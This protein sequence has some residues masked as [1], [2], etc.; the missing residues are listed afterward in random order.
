MSDI[1]LGKL[2]F[3]DVDVENSITKI[4]SQLNKAEQAALKA[5]I[6]QKEAQDKVLQTTVETTKKQND[7]LANALAEAQKKVDEVQKQAVE[8]VKKTES[9]TTA[10]FSGM[11]K[12]IKGFLSTVGTLTGLGTITAI[13]AGM[14]REV[15]K[16]VDKFSRTKEGSKQLENINL[17]W[18]R[19]KA[20]AADFLQ[21]A[22][23]K[24][25][26]I[27]DKALP[28]IERG[29]RKVT[30]FIAGTAA[31]TKGVVNN[32]VSAVKIGLNN[33]EILALKP[34]GVFSA[35]KIAALEE[36]NKKLRESYV[37]I[38]AAAKK[39]YDDQ[40]ASADKASASAKYV[41]E[42]TQEQKKALD[43]YRKAIEDFN[44][45]TEKAQLQIL[46]IE[47]P[48]KKLEKEKELALKAIDDLDKE[49]R[50]AAKKAGKPLPL[51]YETEIKI[52]KDA[53]QLQ[54]KKD[55]Q[56]LIKE[57]T[58][59]VLDGR[60]VFATNLRTVSGDDLNKAIEE[61]FGIAFDIP[62]NVLDD[63]KKAGVKLSNI[64]GYIFTNEEG[65]KKIDEGLNKNERDF[66]KKLTAHVNRTVEITNDLIK[67]RDEASDKQAGKQKNPFARLLGVTD[68]D[69]KE[70]SNTA[71]QIAGNISSIFTT[72]LDNQIQQ[73]D[74]FIQSIRQRISEVENAVN[75][76]SELQARGSANNLATKKKELEELRAQELAKTKENEE[77]NRKRARAQLAADALQQAS[78]LITAG[79][80]IF[81][82]EGI[83]KGAAGIITGILAVSAM[84]AFMAKLRAQAR[85]QSQEL[86][87]YRGGSM[88]K[89][90]GFVNK[91]GRTDK[92]GGKGHKI[93]NSNLVVG[94]KEFISKEEV[95]V[96]HEKFLYD[97]NTGM[98]DGVDLGKIVRIGMVHNVINKEEKKGAAKKEAAV[99][100]EKILYDLNVG[101]F[102]KLDLSQ[103]VR[104]G[105][106][107]RAMENARNEGGLDVLPERIQSFKVDYMV[108]E[109]HRAKAESKYITKKQMQKML[110]KH[111]R[112]LRAHSDEKP[113]YIPITKETTGYLLKSKKVNEK[114]ELE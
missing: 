79:T 99:K 57:L 24:I 17:Q 100:R 14:G 63:A 87:A 80:G 109:K 104:I 19:M 5:A 44:K 38:G 66:A 12:K 86:K 11:G 71:S 62:Q 108:Q 55:L 25:I 32:V 95:S 78:N 96:K 22:L 30:G 49:I 26:P 82:I 70:L 102:D 69:L 89:D 10:I 68:K 114:I 101:M 51:N 16:F 50:A 8:S 46:E 106:A 77:L 85:S 45:N 97:L 40:T 42:L 33:L 20:V 88:E 6:A 112:E 36:E 53:V 111:S 1:V 28:V 98:F 35:S 105:L 23:E 31:F 84:L 2:K 113:Q 110:D 39:A 75:R 76:E 73:N 81:K 64:A 74:L 3:D 83:S 27:L 15:A 93:E 7:A 48:I 91:N 37:D 18:A 59:D 90:Y 52:Q 60:R 47:N 43:D 65:Q 4:I 41:R 94:G 58:K 9:K 21:N 13:F 29:F 67:K 103:I 92:H 72:S 54:F 61:S 56:D 34:F 107:N